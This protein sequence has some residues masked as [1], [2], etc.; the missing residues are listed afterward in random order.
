M[1]SPAARQELIDNGKKISSRL[2]TDTRWH[3]YLAYA[4][5]N[6]H[7]E[8]PHDVSILAMGYQAGADRDK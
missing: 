6:L 8:D 5:L 4:V 3:D 1:L 2:A 7:L